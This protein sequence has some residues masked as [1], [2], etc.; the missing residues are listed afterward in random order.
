MQ[1]TAIE[2]AAR[3]IHRVHDL[4]HA[5]FTHPTD[6]QAALDA[7]LPMFTPG[8]SMVTTAGDV[9]AL[10][11]VTQM[12]RLAAGKRPGLEIAVDEVQPVWRDETGIAMRYRETHRLNG[13]ETS[14][15]SVVI[16]KRAS[17]GL[18]WHYLQ[19]TAVP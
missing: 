7:L 10:D 8:F 5:I 17:Q 16:M 1:D 2:L 4:I 15:R 14:R 13:V 11:Q 19:E 9:V 12:F 3:N 18:L 6:S